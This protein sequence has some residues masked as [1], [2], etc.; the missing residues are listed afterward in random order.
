LVNVVSDPV[1]AQPQGWLPPPTIMKTFEQ[2]IAK[3]KSLSVVVSVSHE[4]TTVDTAT[5]TYAAPNKLRVTALSGKEHE[6]LFC[7][8]SKIKQWNTKNYFV[9]P[10]AANLSDL[11]EGLDFDSYAAEFAVEAFTTPAQFAEIPE[12]SVVGYRDLNGETV[13]TLTATNFHGT[14]MLSVDSITGLPIEYDYLGKKGGFTV[15]F[16]SYKLNAVVPSRDFTA[17][18]P[19]HLTLYV[20]PKE[21]PLLADG[22]PAPDFELPTPAGDIVSLS[23]LKG[24][25]VIVDFWASW[26]PPCKMA[27]PHIQSIY[28]DMKAQGLRVLS[29]N[30]WDDPTFARAYIVDHPWY[31][32]TFLLDTNI[33]K[34][35]A[36]T[37]YK[38]TGIPTA[39]LIDRDGKVA[40]SF[41]GFD[42][43]DEW[44]IRS[45][46]W[47]LGL[48]KD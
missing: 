21:S 8:G 33:K 46:L 20:E 13:E 26:C 48:R 36:S 34:S 18:L 42:P 16:R 1:N 44:K 15:T 41:L 23:S 27:M 12:Y 6:M 10:A 45:A 11:N 40:G 32:T 2:T 39:Y 25:V 17:A 43:G 29:I 5:L 9:G 38:V 35:I 30:T 37:K 7:N 31:Q 24:Q 22:T 3:A 19:K 4:G 47:K 28:S 14:K